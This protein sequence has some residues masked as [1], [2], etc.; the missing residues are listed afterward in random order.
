MGLLGCV[1]PG[2]QPGARSSPSCRSSMEQS[3]LDGFSTLQGCPNHFSR[4]TGTAGTVCL[5]KRLGALSS[6]ERN[7]GECSC[8]NWDRSC[9]TC[10]SQGH[11]GQDGFWLPSATLPASP[12]AGSCS[13]SL[14]LGVPVSQLMG[15]VSSHKSPGSHCSG[16]AEAFL[17]AWEKALEKAAVA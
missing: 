11:Q 2:E 4:H 17:S 5:W 7:P 10:P 12:G 1:V 9:G 14:Q 16:G 6:L 13:L 8:P 3:L 15:R